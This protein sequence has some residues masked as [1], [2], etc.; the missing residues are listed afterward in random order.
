M[1]GLAH[2]LSSPPF[3]D[4]GVRILPSQ[5]ARHFLVHPV[6][7]ARLADCDGG[8]VNAHPFHVT[9]HGAAMKAAH[10]SRI[11]CHGSPAAHVCALHASKAVD[12]V[13]V[14]GE[15]H[16]A[17]TLGA[18]RV[19]CSKEGEHR[20]GYVC[21]EELRLRAHVGVVHLPYGQVLPS[22]PSF[23]R[24]VFDLPRAP[25][26]LGFVAEL[27]ALAVLVAL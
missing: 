8:V 26:L 17:C 20:A 11:R 23:G 1:C 4:G 19:L 14:L 10:L 27:R 18:Q 2:L 25:D 6:L 24:S 9:F 22:L 12:H 16:D 7:V 13:P 3:I 5:V 21:R 15:L